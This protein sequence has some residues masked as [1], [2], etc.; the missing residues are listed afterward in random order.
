MGIRFVTKYPLGVKVV[1]WI[2]NRWAEFF[3]KYQSLVDNLQFPKKYCMPLTPA[4]AFGS[5]KCLMFTLR[6]E[7]ELK[8]IKCIGQR[9]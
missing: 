1:V 4:P 9:P 2:C 3:P 6:L 5:S 8:S 7:P